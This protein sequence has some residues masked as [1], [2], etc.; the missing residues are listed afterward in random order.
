MDF[1]DNFNNS[2]TH[3]DYTPK[4]KKNMNAWY[5]QWDSN[6]IGSIIDNAVTKTCLKK[7]ADNYYSKQL[8]EIL[9]VST[10]LN[11]RSYPIVYSVYKEC[12]S[13]LGIYQMPKAYITG[14]L[15]GINA[16][17]L[18]VKDKQLILISRS[19]TIRLDE[20]ELAFLLGHELGHYQQGNLVCHTVNGL[21]D[22]L[23]NNSE[24]FGPIISDTIEVPLKRWCRSS[25]FNSDRA[26]LICCGNLEIVHGLF[27]KLG[28]SPTLSAFN[29]YSELEQAHPHFKT[30]LEVLS[31]YEITEKP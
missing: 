23:N 22:S 17:C 11:A 3:I 24:I 2:T 28:M 13:K 7:I 5:A 19:A 29:E 9:Q 31:K 27:K 6:Y 8:D 15:R 20:K 4:K 21:L 16:L 30:R 1:V 26:G 12:C 25:E 10:E 14:H 18:D